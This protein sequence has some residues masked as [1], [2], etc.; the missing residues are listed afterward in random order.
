M[1]VRLAVVALWVAG[2]AG[3][4]CGNGGVDPSELGFVVQSAELDFGLL[5]EGDEAVRELTITG[6]G[7]G[8]VQ[9]ELS[10]VAPFSVGPDALVPAG[11]DVTVQVKFR[12][13]SAKVERELLVKGP[14]G[15]AKVKLKGEGRR[16][17]PCVASKPCSL[18]SWDLQTDTCIE[19]MAGDGANCQ[20]E[21]VCLERGR[22]RLGVCEGVARTCDDQDACTVDSCS[23]DQGCVHTPKVCPVPTQACRV[24]TCDSATGCGEGIAADLTGCGPF[25]CVTA[26]LCSNGQCM[27]LQTPEGF[28]CGPPTP[29]QAESRCFNQKCVA[30]D[31]GVM[32]PQ[33][34]QRLGG[35]PSDDAEAIVSHAGNLFTRVCEFPMPLPADAGGPEDAGADAGTDGGTDGGL[36]IAVDAGFELKCVV[37]SF[38]G[39]GFERWTV[40]SVGDGG[41]LLSVGPQ[42]V[43]ELSSDGALL[44]LASLPSGARRE[45]ALPGRTAVDGVAIDSS[46]AVRFVSDGGLWRWRPDAGPQLLA[47]LDGGAEAL[48]IDE[49]GACWVHQPDAGAGKVTLFD[50]GVTVEWL[51]L[52]T[53]AGLATA[54]GA[55]LFGSTH[56]RLSDGG[57]VALQF[58]DAG[59]DAGVL[60]RQSMMGLNAAV[61]FTGENSAVWSNVFRLDDGQPLWRQKVLPEDVQGRVVTSTLSGVLPG[62]FATVVQ[63]SLDGG[64]Q[65]FLEGFAENKRVLLCPFEEGAWFQGGVFINGRLVMR[66]RHFDGGWVL[67]SF[68]LKSLPV[69]ETGW[70]QQSSTAGARR[71][72]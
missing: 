62:A 47:G 3:C 71:A 42:G 66:G 59:V 45:L 13:G 22:C 64:H 72:R 57:V 9:V 48:A 21:S 24:A 51:A 26:K 65:A 4:R 39:T 55:T 35:V 44:S 33:W 16:P 68:D 61:V 29:C 19:S 58:A 18:S 28:I 7:R 17:K 30:P 6:T 46:G 36:P 63:V 43:V 12:A 11:S 60:S 40:A 23:P 34:V 1:R 53:G 52:A 38:T 67:E 14:A 5:K 25:D 56:L 20:P 37:R 27:S 31:A 8:V 10:T 69:L 70:P 2:A 41:A 49:A 15:E 54:Q 50:G 32:K